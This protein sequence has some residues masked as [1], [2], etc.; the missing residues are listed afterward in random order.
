[1]HLS[2]ESGDMSPG[3]LRLSGANRHAELIGVHSREKVTQAFAA[4]SNEPLRS[5]PGMRPFLA[6][7]RF[8]H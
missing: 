5:K 8:R 2:L 3:L 1:M 6:M 7:V 4:L